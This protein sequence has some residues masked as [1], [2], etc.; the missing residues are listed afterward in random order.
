MS[1]TILDQHVEALP[2]VISSHSIGADTLRERLRRPEGALVLVNK[3][4]GETSFHIVSQIRRR[5]SPIDGIKRVKVGHAGTLD[6]LATGLLIIAT[7]GAT[8]S[9]TSLMGLDKVYE[10]RLRLGVES[11][12]FDLETPIRVIADPSDLSE[13]AIREVV[14][15]FQGASMQAPPIYSAIKQS[16]KPVY[17]R[18]R[19]GAEVILSMRSIFV[20]S[21]EVLRIEMPF[22]DIWVECTKG[23]YIRSLV[24]DIGK[25]LGCGAVMT[26]L[27]R[28][29]IGEYQLS[30]SFEFQEL[31]ELLEGHGNY[32][33]LAA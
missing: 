22:L 21:I 33:N 11:P 18:A 23:T 24:Q 7:R 30:D 13:L 9:I 16:G 15:S 5:I 25:K 27:V 4:Y 20:H 31:L 2:K 10:L 28:T 19:A 1:E 12:S 32:H 3:P 6:P 8:K 17:L 29:A 14:D 26:G